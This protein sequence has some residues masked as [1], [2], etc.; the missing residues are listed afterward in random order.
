MGIMPLVSIITPF[1]NS[2]SYLS[3][4]FDSVIIQTYQNLELILVNDGSTDRSEE[5]I[6]QYRDL[7]A[8]RNIQFKYLKYPDNHGQAYALNLGLK[9]FSGKY[10]TWIDSDDSMTDNC[11]EEKVS[12]L[13]QY[14]EFDY[15]VCNTRFI[16]NEFRNV[17]RIAKPKVLKDNIKIFESLIF[18]ETG[19]Y[20]PGAYLVRS[21]FIDQYFKGR[22]IYTGRGGQNAQMLIPCAWYGKI[23]YIDKPLYNYI[24]RDD[25]HS[26]SKNT[27]QK[28]IRQ[29]ENFE[30][31]LINTIESLNDSQASLYIPEVKRKY[32]RAR[33]GYA[34]D[35]YDSTTIRNAAKQLKE[36]RIYTMHDR[37]LV[38]RFTN[39]LLQIFC[40][41]KKKQKNEKEDRSHT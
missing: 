34:L 28:Q 5:V 27:P 12:F 22:S 37:Y 15:C 21:K 10:V 31:I 29:L 14:K 16:D 25:S 24:V 39:K 26:H 30:A 7:L 32:A 19:Y 18:G 2:E 41:A 20:V 35:T 8:K 4:F 11:I 33:F 9:E 23:G 40:P 6:E 13:E 17:L 3:S 36:L 1:Y 38:F